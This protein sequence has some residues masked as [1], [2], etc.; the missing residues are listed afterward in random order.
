MKAIAIFG[1]TSAIAQ[2]VAR[3]FAA[4]PC[5]FFL[6]A[7]NEQRLAAVAADLR[8]RGAAVELAVCDLTDI[9][10]QAGLIEQVSTS[11]RTIDYALFA[12]GTLPEQPACEADAALSLQQITVNFLSTAGLLTHLAPVMQRQ[13]HGTIG[14]I[15]SVAGDRGRQSNYV[16]GSAKG[17]LAVFVQGLRHRLWSS[18]VRVVLIKPGFV[19]TPMTA[20]FAKGGP[21]WASPDKVG[22]DIVSA[23]QRGQAVLYTPW[24]WRGIMLIIRLVP[25]FI[26]RRTRL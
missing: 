4:E 10:A 25:D 14:V 19:D 2:A 7:R 15:G 3:S 22:R 16:Y 26:F 18:G 13:A 5:R 23:L 24:F 17:G 21:L 12:H 20:G 8:T 9:N 11:L 1:A 6:V